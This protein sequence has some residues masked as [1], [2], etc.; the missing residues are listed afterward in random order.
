MA[1]VYSTLFWDAHLTAITNDL[2]TVP[3][4]YVDVIRQVSWHAPISYPYFVD[5]AHLNISGNTGLFAAVPVWL[6]R[7]G[8]VYDVQGHWVVPAGSLVLA[9]TPQTGWDLRASGYRLTL[10]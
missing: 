6:T 1:N 9:L 8:V 7:G 3:A 4:G 10:P 2:W 5:T